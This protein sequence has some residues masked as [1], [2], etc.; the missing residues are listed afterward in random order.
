MSSQLVENIL[1]YSSPLFTGYFYE[2]SLPLATDKTLFFF[3]Q[4]YMDILY[5]FSTKTYLVSTH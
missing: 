2:I 3:Q 4:K 5:Y 1:S